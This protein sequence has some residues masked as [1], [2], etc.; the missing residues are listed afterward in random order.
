GTSSEGKG[1]V[2]GLTEKAR[3]MAW[4]V[5]KDGKTT[6]VTQD[7]ADKCHATFDVVVKCRYGSVRLKPDAAL[8]VKDSGPPR[9]PARDSTRSDPSRTRCGSC[10]SSRRGPRPST[11]RGRRSP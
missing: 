11:T 8:G 5:K 6:E 9:R 2:E 4:E 10:R 3:P 1:R 7:V